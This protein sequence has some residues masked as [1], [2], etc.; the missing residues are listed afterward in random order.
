VSTWTEYG[1]AAGE[2][3]VWPAASRDVAAAYARHRGAAA[4]WRQVRIGP[5][6]GSHDTP[7]KP[8][9]VTTGPWRVL[10][11]DRR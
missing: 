7:D 4:V 3:T 5:R 11:G 6:G 9:R 2:D 8:P 10:K 1:V